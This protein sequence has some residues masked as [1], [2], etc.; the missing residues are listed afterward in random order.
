MCEAQAKASLLLSRV[1]PQL[2]NDWTYNFWKIS[3]INNL[4]YQKLLMLNGFDRNYRFV[5]FTHTHNYTFSD[6]LMMPSC[7]WERNVI[8]N[9]RN[10]IMIQYEIPNSQKSIIIWNYL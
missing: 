6:Q 2:S 5:I 3:S 4:S 1:P 8:Y 10:E 9:R 7:P